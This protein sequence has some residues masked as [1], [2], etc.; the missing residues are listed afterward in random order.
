MASYSHGIPT[1]RPL[2]LQS[3]RTL[4]RH[5]HLRRQQRILQRLGRHRDVAEAT[6]DRRHLHGSR[7]Q[8][9]RHRRHLLRRRQRTRPRPR[10]Q[11]SPPRRRP[12]L[13]QGH[14]PSRHRPQRRRLLA[15]PPHPR[16]SRALSSA[17]APTTSTSTTCTAS[18]PSPPS[19][20]P[21][22]P[23]TSFV[24]DGKIRYI[25]CSNFSGWHLMKSLS[26]S[27]RYGW[28]RYVGH[29]AYYS[30]VGRDYEWELMPLGPRPGRRR[31]RLVPAR[32]G[33]PHRQNPPRTTGLPKESRLNSKAR[34]RHGPASPRGVPLQS[35][36]RPRRSRHRNRQNRPPDR[37]QLAPPP[38]HRLHRSSSAP[39]T[40]HNSA[41][42]S[43]PSAGT[44]TP[45]QIAKLD[46][47]SDLPPPT[48]TGT[49]ANSPN[50]IRSSSKRNTRRFLGHPATHTPF[51][52]PPLHLKM[53]RW[54]AFPTY[55]ETLSQGHQSR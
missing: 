27:E 26:V 22:T 43:A 37:P 4:L 31:P 32:L 15:L 5:R 11:A 17:S 54:E 55:L 12:H 30:L 53:R 20:K 7:P 40:R 1:T 29:Q 16:H 42:T 9:L 2:R 45:A 8:L 49:S 3:P 36:R 46:A 51:F 50:A 25:A 14:L 13:H 41:R 39:A 52:V 6:Q 28:T 23:S 47:A 24:R 48:P 18:T 10:H 35:R 33:P 21:S 19:K 38:P 34:P 44:L